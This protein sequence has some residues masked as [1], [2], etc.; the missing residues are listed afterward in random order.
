MHSMS[1]VLVI[2]YPLLV[3]MWGMQVY[4][5][6][7][8]EDTQK[9]VMN[10][11]AQPQIPANDPKFAYTVSKNAVSFILGKD[12]RDDTY[13]NQYWARTSQFILLDAQADLLGGLMDF[14]L[15]VAAC[16]YDGVSVRIAPRAALSL[17]TNALFISA[18]CFEEQSK[19][20]YQI[21][22]QRVQ[23]VSG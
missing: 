10:D 18:F 19:T 12:E 6:Q 17:M 20:C 2:T 3:R 1:V 22:L 7:I 21:C 15:S 23:A 9:A 4:V 14:D 11:V 5:M 8:S 16:S 13:G